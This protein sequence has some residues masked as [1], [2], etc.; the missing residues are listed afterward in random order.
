[1]IL[2]IV[3]VNYN[4]EEILRNCLAS[5]FTSFKSKKFAGQTEIIVIDNHSTDGSARYLKSQNLKFKTAAKN[6]KLRKEKIKFDN[7]PSRPPSKPDQIDNLDKLK[8]LI[9]IFN[10]KN[11]GFAKANNQ[12]IKIS[13]GKFVLLLNSDTLIEKGSLEQLVNFAA[14]KADAGAVVPRLLNHDGSTQGSCCRLPTLTSAFKEF[15][16]NQKGAFLKYAP[17]GQQP[18]LVEAAVGAAFLITPLALK[19]AGLLDEQ[20]F[21]YFEDLDYCRRLAK[22]GLKIYYLPQAA[23]THLHGASGKNLKS[24]PNQWLVESSKKYYR[25]CNHYLINFIIWSGQKW[26]KLRKFF[27]ACAEDRGR[28]KGISSGSGCG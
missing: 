2:S 12:G 9:T 1:M 17:E 14:N 25:S 4:T 23:I 3:I 26:Q 6:A 20:Y 5:I 22:Q 13:K 7:S 24:K 10:K 27:S 15:F 8:N 18:V 19:K 16:L 21:M 11:L 28:P